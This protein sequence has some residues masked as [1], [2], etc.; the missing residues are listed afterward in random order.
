VIYG[1][2]HKLRLQLNEL[3]DFSIGRYDSNDFSIFSRFVSSHQHCLLRQIAFDEVELHAVARSCWVVS[4]RRW[5]E[6]EKGKNVRLVHCQPFRLIRPPKNGSS[7][8]DIA[9]KVTFRLL[10][11]P[12]DVEFSRERLSLIQVPKL[13]TPSLVDTDCQFEYYQVQ[14]SVPNACVRPG[15]A[16][17]DFQY[18]L[19][20]EQNQKRPTPVQQEGSEH[21]TAILVW[22][23]G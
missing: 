10:Q 9:S 2:G 5:T 21:Y 17:F 4:E 23:R 18:K 16:S 19:L 8:S 22:S 6:V 7:S 1:Q 13:M 11:L 14:L 3:S 15:S 12:A 20:L